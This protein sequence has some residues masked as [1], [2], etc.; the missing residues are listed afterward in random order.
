MPPKDKLVKDKKKKAIKKNDIQQETTNDSEKEIIIPKKKGIDVIDDQK[1]IVLPNDKVKIKQIIHVSDIHISKNASRHQEYS[2]VFER[3]YDSIKHVSTDTLIVVTGDIT[4]EKSQLSPDQI[5]LVKD[6]FIM[7]SSV[8]N[9]ICIIGNHDIN[10]NC[11]SIDALTSILKNLETKNKIH[12][13]LDD[14]VYEYNNILFGLTTMFTKTVT[15]CNIETDKIKI[16]LYHGI[17]RGCTTDKD[18][19]ISNTDNFNMSDFM[20]H[21]DLC[22]LGD[23]HKFCYMN[24]EKTMAYAGSLIQQNIGEN[25]LDHGYIMWNLENKTSEFVRIKN[26]NGMIHID[27]N[28]NGIEPYDKKSIPMY[29]S[30]YLYYSNITQ[31]KANEYGDSFMKKYPKGKCYLNSVKSNVDTNITIGKGIEKKNLTDIKNNES[32][33]KI[34]MEYMVK[35]ESYQQINDTQKE[36]LDKCM[37]KIIK[38]L[39][40]NFNSNTKN[41][42]LKSLSFDNFFLYTDDNKIDFDKKSKIVGLVGPSYS[43]KSTIIDVLL[44]GIFGKC[45]RGNKFDIVNKTCDYVSICVDFEVNT[46]L[47]KIKRRRTIQKGNKKS[48]E[49]ITIMKDNV[50]ITNDKVDRINADIEKI[51]GTY[52]D[53]INVSIMLQKSCTSFADLKDTSRKELICKLLKLDMFNDILASAKHRVVAINKDINSYTKQKKS[54]KKQKEAI[55]ID[56]K[57]KL[58]EKELEI[59]NNDIIKANNSEETMIKSL[60]SQK[61]ILMEYEFKAKELNKLKLVETKL[62][63]VVKAIKKLEIDTEKYNNSITTL[64][65]KVANNKN[66]LVKVNNKMKTYKDIDALHERF[67]IDKKDAIDELTDKYDKLLTS[68]GAEVKCKYNIN[69]LKKELD[70]MKDSKEKMDNDNTAAQA[71]IKKISI[72]NIKF[73][74]LDEKNYKKLQETKEILITKKEESKKINKDITTLNKKLKKLAGHEFDENCKFCIKYSVTQDKISYT[75][76][77]KTITENE[78]A[79]QVE[80]DNCNDTIK[81]LSKYE[82]IYNTYIEELD[83]NKQNEIQL[84]KY[85]NIILINNK[86]IE[87]LDGKIEKNENIISEHDKIA[88]IMKQNKII[89]TKCNKLKVEIENKRN[90][91]CTEYYTFQELNKNKLMLENIIEKLNNEIKELKHD[92]STN[93]S[94][95]YKLTIEKNGYDDN[96]KNIENSK[97]LESEYKNLKNT[98]NEDN[99][100]YQTLLK[101][102][103]LLNENLAKIKCEHECEKQQIAKYMKLIDEKKLLELIV[104]TFGDDDGLINDVLTNSIFPSLEEQV[105]GIL[106]SIADYKIRLV[107]RA[108]GIDII[109]ISKDGTELNIDTIS[110]CESFVSNIAFRLALSEYNNFIKTNF[111]I[112]D[113]SFLFCDDTN[114]AKIPALFEYIRNHFTWG[115]IISHDER[116][117][118]LYNSVIN[119]EKIGSASRIT[120]V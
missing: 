63:N 15:E 80:I 26:D 51:V 75:N 28:E 48:T 103:A 70:K 30:F 98:F 114:I 76:E 111:I 1:Y 46:H 113:E 93:D 117:I 69:T 44:Y 72:K 89:N 52:D 68:R 27:I 34:I 116:I 59:I 23:I 73:S 10:P 87:I 35:K 41:F 74:K 107:C 7:L 119:I 81:K 14:K 82:K 108:K 96:N 92:I 84:E 77:L 99:L 115:L 100:A 50:N 19:Q 20:K 38:D 37:I 31:T 36:S 22:L 49:A 39:D 6:F 120:S 88:E 13:L 79:L 43:G 106:K 90:E 40:Y 56:A 78:E 18:F 64:E 29:P 112:I 24:K 5:S 32:V 101:D 16:G 42:K 85:K 45:S 97:K 91:K 2:E 83:K 33:K 86:D 55:I 21:Y 58:I 53:F 60:D 4:H 94:K 95:I 110:G 118:K 9:V 71:N 65:A 67:L 3:L 102:K 62:M 25:L 57:I 109:K 66:D 47:Y 12:L 17:I 105:N 104:D 8:T 61:A 54:T 11:S